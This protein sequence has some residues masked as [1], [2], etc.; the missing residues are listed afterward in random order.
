MNDIENK[1]I[2]LFYNFSFI[3]C[4]QDLDFLFPPV[5]QKSLDKVLF[6]KGLWTIKLETFT[7]D[8]IWWIFLEVIEMVLLFNYYLVD[9]FTFT[10]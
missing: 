6:F 1:N 8:K 7:S 5:Q 2:R 10:I 4:L 3:T 9:V